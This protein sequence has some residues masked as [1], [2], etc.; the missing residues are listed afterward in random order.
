[1][2]EVL[3]KTDFLG[4]D[5]VTGEVTVNALKEVNLSVEKGKFVVIIGPSGCG[6]TT[7]LNLIGGIDRPSEGSI[8]VGAKVITNMSEKEL[9]GFRKE[10]IGFIFQFYNL[11]PA[12]NALENVELSA[13]L[14]FPKDAYER[15]LEMLK[16]VGLEE[17]INKYPS[18]LSGGEQQRVAIARALAKEPKV[19][20]A[21]EPTGNLDSKTGKAIINLMLDI[22]RNQKTTFLIVTHDVSISELADQ[23]V[24]L[25]DG[26]VIKT[27]AIF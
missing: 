15:S 14:K 27:S 12:L 3:I 13:R 10:D 18:Q 8:T 16:R 2:S 22:C 20:L 26:Q 24:H 6:K 23:I 17:K 25:Q 11:I 21:D 1:M 19:V 5:Y 9:T 7:L 4:K